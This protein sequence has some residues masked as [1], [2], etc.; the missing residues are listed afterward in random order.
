[1]SEKRVEH[2]RMLMAAQER[3]AEALTPYGV[4]DAQLEAALGAAEE[5]LPQDERDDRDFFLQALELYVGSLGGRL[6]HNVAVFPN[7]AVTIDQEG[8]G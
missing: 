2:F 7:V 1:L 5:A 6:E 4:T 8:Q 3:I